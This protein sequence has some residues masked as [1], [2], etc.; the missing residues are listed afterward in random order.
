MT[1]MFLV[2]FNLTFA[3]HDLVEKTPP[4]PP[5]VLVSPKPLARIDPAYIEYGNFSQ[6]LTVAAQ[7]RRS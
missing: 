7:N 5:R 3:R 6:L 4:N 2:K 1:K